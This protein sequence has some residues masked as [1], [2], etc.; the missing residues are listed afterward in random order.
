MSDNLEPAQRDNLEPVGYVTGIADGRKLFL[1][2]DDDVGIALYVAPAIHAYVARAVAQE[3][4]RILV[5]AKARYDHEAAGAVVAHSANWH[6]AFEWHMTRQAAMGD[7]LDAI[8]KG[9]P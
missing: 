9:S 6:A 4:E 1:R 7:M 3:R 2:D 5:V 8:R